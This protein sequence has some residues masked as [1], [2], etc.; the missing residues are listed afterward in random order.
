MTTAQ[1]PPAKHEAKHQPASFGSEHIVYIF[2]VAIGAWVAARF[3]DGGVPVVAAALVAALVP[4][5]HGWS[6]RGPIAV[7]AGLLA[8]LI[9]RMWPM[10]GAGAEAAA[11]PAESAHLLSW[12]IGLPI[13]GA[14]AVLLIPRESQ[15][16]L[17]WT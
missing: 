17:Q 8:L 11:P 15:R 16:A 13:A 3:L 1:T 9:V 2:F 5:E 6:V 7:T 14:I 10:A 12:I 4:K